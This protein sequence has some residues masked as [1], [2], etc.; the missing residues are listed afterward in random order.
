[1]NIVETLVFGQEKMTPKVIDEIMP[2]SLKHW[3]EVGR[4]D[5]E[6]SPDWNMYFMGSSN[7]IVQCFTAR[8]NGV[9]KGYS[10]F[11][12][13]NHPHY[14]TVLTAIQDTLFLEKDERKGNVGKHFIRY[15]E[16][17]LKAMG[18]DFVNQSVTFQ[19]DFGPV[20]ERLGYVP[21]GVNYERRI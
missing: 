13:R 18:I 20:L 15:C 16:I 1:M 7:N 10:T 2:L 8:R 17:G 6:F 19:N 4:K 9:L 3:I 11:V 14:K 21:T 5:L 12:V